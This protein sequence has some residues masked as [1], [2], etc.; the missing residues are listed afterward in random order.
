MWFMRSYNSVRQ[1]GPRLSSVSVFSIG[2]IFFIQRDSKICIRNDCV[3]Y[4]CL[5]RFTDTLLAIPCHMDAW[6]R[7]KFTSLILISDLTQRSFLMGLK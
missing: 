1:I 4:I 6:R 3:Y 2:K 7:L 5:R